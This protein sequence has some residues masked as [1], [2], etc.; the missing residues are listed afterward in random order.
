M[1]SCSIEIAELIFFFFF[2]LQKDP[3]LLQLAAEDVLD[4]MIDEIILGVIY[5]V[6]LSYLIRIR[7]IFLHNRD[8]SPVFSVFTSGKE[9]ESKY[10]Q[11]LLCH[12]ED[13]L[14]TMIDEIILG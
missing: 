10:V 3:R 8:F 12:A 9:I 14:D 7:T 1:A 11:T 6:F 5:L 13:V 2:L 4:T